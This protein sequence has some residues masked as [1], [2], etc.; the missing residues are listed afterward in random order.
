MG[1]NFKFHQAK[2]I[3]KLNRISE[4]DFFE[5]IAIHLN[6]EVIINKKKYCILLST[7]WKN[8]FSAINYSSLKSGNAFIFILFYFQICLH[9]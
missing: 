3:F 6:H 8:L 5:N 7:A 2:I 9:R 1:H 4:L